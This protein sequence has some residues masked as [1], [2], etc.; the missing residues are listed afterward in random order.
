MEAKVGAKADMDIHAAW[1]VVAFF[2][3]LLCI[4]GVSPKT[5]NE[6][7]TATAV[8]LM[9]LPSVGALRNDKGN[10]TS[11]R[12]VSARK[13][14]SQP[15]RDILSNMSIK[16]EAGEP[17]DVALARWLETLLSDDWKADMHEIG[18][19]DA[20]GNP[21]AEPMGMA[22]DQS[23]AMIDQ[24]FADGV[25]FGSAVSGISFAAAGGPMDSLLTAHADEVA[26]ESRRSRTAIIGEVRAAGAEL[27]GKIDESKD[28]INGEVR[29]AGVELSGKIDESGANLGSLKNKVKDQTLLSRNVLAT[30]GKI[31]EAQMQSQLESLGL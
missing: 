8:A 4:Q 1:R 9:G 17:E 23:S 11:G 19:I 2:Y 21:C 26:A 5:A 20:N 3:V 30:V 24:A 6:R 15:M 13:S 31:H 28:A 18:L 27:S 12:T 29:A 16:K 14:A 22:G 25:V 10:P 7:A